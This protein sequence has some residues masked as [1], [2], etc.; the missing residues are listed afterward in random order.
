MTD[1]FEKASL[2]LANRF[3]TEPAS[4]RATERLETDDSARSI[5]KAKHE[6]DQ[7]FLFLAA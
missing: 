4:L 5:S 3:E 1:K 2:P 7:V 6:R